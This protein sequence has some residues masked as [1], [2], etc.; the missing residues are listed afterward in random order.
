MSARMPPLPRRLPIHLCPYRRR[1]RPFS[2]SSPR[3]D[4]ASRA[5]TLEDLKEIDSIAL[6]TTKRLVEAIGTETSSLASMT[7][8]IISQARS[9]Q[10]NSS[11]PSYMPAHWAQHRRTFPPKL[12]I[13]QERV[14]NLRRNLEDLEAVPYAEEKGETQSQ[15]VRARLRAGTEAERRFDTQQFK[16]EEETHAKR[17]DAVFDTLE[18]EVEAWRGSHHPGELPDQPAFKRVA[19]GTTMVVAKPRRAGKR[20]TGIREQQSKSPIRPERAAQKKQDKSSSPSKVDEPAMGTGRV[21]SSPQTKS[22]G[23][24]KKAIPPKKR[25]LLTMQAKLDKSLET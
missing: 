5:D 14:E 7:G 17:L 4:A 19:W 22:A 20:R 15:K 13:L 3:R 23:E 10:L 6:A 16:F 1:R 11:I 12:N 2:S 8:Q 21:E 24:E 18:A 9:V 25:D